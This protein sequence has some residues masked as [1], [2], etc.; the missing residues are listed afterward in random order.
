MQ[1]YYKELKIKWKINNNN[2]IAIFFFYE[3]MLFLKNVF[4]HKWL[5]KEI[6]ISL[7][8]LIKWYKKPHYCVKSRFLEATKKK[9]KQ[10]FMILKLSVRFYSKYLIVN[11][12]KEQSYVFFKLCIF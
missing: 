12:I 3:K 2:N 7:F 10:H 9:K 1:V 8:K 11:N 4:I 6:P 5:F